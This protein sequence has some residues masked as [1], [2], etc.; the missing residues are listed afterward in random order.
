MN[1]DNGNN[2]IV[3]A[4]QWCTVSSPTSVS[5]PTCYWQTEIVSP[6]V[7]VI[8]RYARADNATWADNLSLPIALGL[9]T[10]DGRA[11]NTPC[12]PP[13]SCYCYIILI[14]ASGS[15][16]IVTFSRLD[17]R[18]CVP[19]WRAIVFSTRFG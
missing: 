7:T 15:L 2:M 9:T 14:R 12:C 11:D 18:R 10:T 16:G 6:R 1:N 5:P 8:P 19:Q 3:V 13:K 17:N 4:Q